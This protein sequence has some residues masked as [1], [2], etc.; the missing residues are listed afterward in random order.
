MSFEHGQKLAL[1]IRIGPEP[2]LVSNFAHL[3]PLLAFDVASLTWPVGSPGD[4]PG[5]IGA[6]CFRAPPPPPQATQ[7]TG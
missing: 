7:L 4:D 6:S 2:E 1:L 5:A 3:F